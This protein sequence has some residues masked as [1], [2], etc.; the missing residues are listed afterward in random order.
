M[1]VRRTRLG[2]GIAINP[3]LFRDIA[4]TTFALE[5]PDLVSLTKDLLNHASFATTDKFYLQAQSMA[6]GRRY[7]AV[8]R[9][10]RHRLLMRSQPDA[11]PERPSRYV[12]L[13]ST[14]T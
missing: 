10:M 6:A 14:S 12:W 13:T 11:S 3:H 1:I 8:G 5:R 2:L 9:A 7:A 4:A